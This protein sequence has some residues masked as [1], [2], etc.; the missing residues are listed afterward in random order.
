MSR[1]S[2][3]LARVLV[4]A[5]RQGQALRTGD[6][7]ARGVAQDVPLYTAARLERRAG[8]LAGRVES[9]VGVS[10]RVSNIREDLPVMS[11]EIPQ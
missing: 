4:V 10:V 7:S 6:R 5:V 9:Y 2:H 1:Y 8:A 11:L 3:P